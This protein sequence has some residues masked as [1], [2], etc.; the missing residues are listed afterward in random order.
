MT[1]NLLIWGAIFA[2]GVYVGV[3]ATKQAVSDRIT[4]GVNDLADRTGLSN[5]TYGK[6]VVNQ[7]N[8]WIKENFQ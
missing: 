4:G 3:Q 8:G 2:A 7:V 1:R 6:P 5:T